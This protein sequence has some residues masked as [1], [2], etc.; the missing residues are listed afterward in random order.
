MHTIIDKAG[1]DRLNH[2]QKKELLGGLV[3]FL[4]QDLNGLE[5]KYLL[6]KIV[7]CGRDDPQ[8]IDMV[9]H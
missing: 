3:A 8:V 7:S 5:K 4:V 2:S 9:E 1:L 6:Q